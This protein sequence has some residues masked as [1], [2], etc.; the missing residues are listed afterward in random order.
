M[1]KHALL[2]LLLTMLVLVVLAAVVAIIGFA[3]ARWDGAS[4]PASITRGCIAFAAA[5]TLGTALIATLLP[6]LS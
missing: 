3:L 1:S 2:F 5:L 4:I 6:Q